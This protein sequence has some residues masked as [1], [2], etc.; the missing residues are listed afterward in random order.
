MPFTLLT[1]AV[2]VVITVVAFVQTTPRVAR[3][4]AALAFNVAVLAGSVPLA[5]VVGAWLFGDAV[6]VKAAEKG[7]ATYLAIMGGA[8]AA[9]GFIAVCGLL[10]NFAV[11]PRSRRIPE[12]AHE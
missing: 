1:L 6:A 10:R 8:C 9:L 2:V 12:P 4:R 3:P 11:F 7:M 5:I